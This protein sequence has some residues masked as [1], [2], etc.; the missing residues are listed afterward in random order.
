MQKFWQILGVALLTTSLVGAM[1]LYVDARPGFGNGPCRRGGSQ[2]FRVLNAID[3]TQEQQNQIETIRD[4]HRDATEA[5]RTESQTIR[6]DILDTLLASGALTTDFATEVTQL[7]DLAQQ[8][9]DARLSMLSDVRDVL[10]D[11][12]RTEAAD[13]IESRQALC[14]ELHETF[15]NSDDTEQ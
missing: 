2:L 15:G 4:N 1:A 9:I 6:Q 5:I 11:T 12:Q 3:L 8:R 10:T 13:L 7:G 14:N